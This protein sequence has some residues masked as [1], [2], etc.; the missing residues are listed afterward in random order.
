MLDAWLDL[1]HGGGCVG[2]CAAGAIAVRE[3][4]ATPADGGT[5]ARPTPCPDGLAACFAAGEYDDLLRAMVLAHKEHGTFSLAAPLGRVLAACGDVR[6]RPDAEDRA[7]AGALPTGRWS[8]RVVTTRCSGW[9]VRR[10]GC[11]G[12]AATVSGSP[13]CSTQRGVVD[14]Q[15]GLDAGQRAANLAGSMG[16]RAD[17]SSGPGPLRRT[18]VAAGLR[19]RPHD[20]VP[21]LARHSGRSRIRSPGPRRGDG[22]SH[23]EAGAARACTTLAG[24]YRFP[25]MRTSV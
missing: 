5:A 24:P 21:P 18:V 13:R 15:A 8:A 4:A 25:D 11:S 22:R 9:P 20:R 1:V 12:A 17:G 10:L 14:D 19:R 7:G 2:L 23:A 6:S 16:V 3:C